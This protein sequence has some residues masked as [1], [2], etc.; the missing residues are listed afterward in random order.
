MLKIKNLTI[1]DED[2]KYVDNLTLETNPGELH[3][4]IG[5]P[6]AGKSFIAHAIFGN[7]ELAITSGEILFKNKS[8][9]K[10]SMADRS[11][12]GIFTSFQDP[13][14]LSGV[15]NFELIRAVAAANKDKRTSNELTAAFKELCKSLELSSSHGSKVLDPDD[16]VDTRK[17]EMLQLLLLNPKLFVLDEI[18]DGLEADDMQVIGDHLN[19]FM[20]STK[21]GII[22]TKNPAFLD[23]INPTHVHVMVNGIL[24]TLDTPDLYKRFIID[25]YSQFL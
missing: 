6:G 8:L 18:D 19:T 5:L 1:E 16:I 20:T 10:K 17:N 9:A 2:N 11:K 23:I 4:V 12:L 13:P 22:L 25:D 24:A 21:V 7:P 15:T 14:M 3:A